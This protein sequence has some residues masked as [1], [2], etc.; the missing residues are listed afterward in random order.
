M[1]KHPERFGKYEVLSVIGK[2]G[3]GVVYLARD[4]NIDRT[5]AVKTIGSPDEESRDELL[6]RLTMEARSAGRL[7]HR[8]IVTIHDFGVQDDV[9]YIVMEFIE[10]TNLGAMI[11]RHEPISLDQKLDILIQLCDGMAYAHELGVLHRDLKPS[12]VALTTKH[13]VKILDFGLARF[14]STRLTQAGFLSGTIPYMSPERIN[15]DSGAGD[16]IF[17]IGAVA[18]EFLSGQRA[19]QG[20]TPPEV[21]Y[22]VLNGHPAALSKIAKL[23]EELDTIIGRALEKDVAKRFQSARELGARLEEFRRSPALKSYLYAEKLV[24]RLSDSTM[25]RRTDLDRSGSRSRRAEA[26]IAQRLDA[27]TPRRTTPMVPAPEM[28]TEPMTPATPTPPP[29]LP[30]EPP[31]PIFTT[32]PFIPPTMAEEMPRDEFPLVNEPMPTQIDTPMPSAPAIPQAPAPSFTPVVPPPVAPVAARAIPATMADVPYSNV[33][34]TLAEVP[35]SAPATQAISMDEVMPPPHAPSRPRL[36]IMIVGAMIVLLLGVGAAVVYRFATSGSKTP[37]AETPPDTAPAL[38][39]TVETQQS[40]FRSLRDRASQL[41]PTAELQ[42]ALQSIDATHGTA[43]SRLEGNDFAAASTLLGDSIAQLQR[44]LTAPQGPA[45]TATSPSRPD[46]ATALDEWTRVNN[47]IDAMIDRAARDGVRLDSNVAARLAERKA[48]V[49]ALLEAGRIDEFSAQA[50]P[51]VAAY[52]EAVRRA[53]YAKRSEAR[54]TEAKPKPVVPPPTETAEEVVEAPPPPPVETVTVGRAEPARPIHQASPRVPQSTIR[55]RA[56]GTVVVEVTIDTRGIVS[57]ARIVKPVFPS[58]DA[59]ALRAAKQW[60]FQP[61]T[62]NG[63]AVESR[64][65][66]QFEFKP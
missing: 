18:Y 5:V 17:A 63:E 65:T 3:M 40:T 24:D 4:P 25:A 54:R 23:P 49:F 60:R 26:D 64:M 32:R 20:R 7:Q 38:A 11:A 46:V 66:L 52:E 53:A 58:Y 35:F 56:E 13:I 43:L 51:L 16:D 6:K 36:G 14:D 21:M 45:T 48:G 57:G 27:F 15:G 19:F 9:S 59:A 8:N 44:I 1:I 29:A 42:Q 39:K 37:G 50:Q 34:A 61:A 30:E 28:L 41:P 62:I 55:V 22:Q 10:G 31:P 47:S 12:N 2:G 33:P